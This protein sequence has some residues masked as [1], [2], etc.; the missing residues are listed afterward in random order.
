M[1]YLGWIADA[2]IVG[3]LWR[4]GNRSRDA[5]II[6]SLGNLIWCAVAIPC[7]ELGTVGAVC[8]AHFALGKRVA[9]VGTMKPCWCGQTGWSKWRCYGARISGAI[10]DF[11]GSV[12]YW[13]DM[14]EWP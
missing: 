7:R 10:S 14:G 12:A 1:E 3:G 5:F 13:F 11:F 2:F 8:G 9:E 6:Q 4:M